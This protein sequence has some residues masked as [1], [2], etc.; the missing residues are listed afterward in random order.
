MSDIE[1]SVFSETALVVTIGRNADGG[2]PLDH[3]R[4][5]EYRSGI[6]RI[7]REFVEEGP[8]GGL[9]VVDDNIGQGVD[10][11]NCVFVGLLNNPSVDEVEALG[12]EGF[13]EEIERQAFRSYVFEHALA[14]WA[15]GFGQTSLAF[16][17]GPNVLLLAHEDQ[18]PTEEASDDALTA[19]LDEETLKGLED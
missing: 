2:E 10:G 19:L 18:T 15:H 11:D 3:A 16:T 4:W 17:Y 6:A 8:T 9:L 13:R 7:V 5:I 12:E 1:R 14:H